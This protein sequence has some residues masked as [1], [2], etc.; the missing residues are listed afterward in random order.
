MCQNFCSADVCTGEV[1]AVRAAAE[2]V[3][4]PVHRLPPMSLYGNNENATKQR[5][6]VNQ[7]RTH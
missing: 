6:I 7:A 4:P 1:V 2:A 5:F 3:R